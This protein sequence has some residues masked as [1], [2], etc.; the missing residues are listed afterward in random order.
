MLTSPINIAKYINNRSIKINWN[1][2]NFFPNLINFSDYKKEVGKR[3][4][5]NIYFSYKI[6]ID[7][8]PRHSTECLKYENVSKSE[9]ITLKKNVTYFT[10]SINEFLEFVTLWSSKILTFNTINSSLRSVDLCSE[11]KKQFH[12]TATTILERQNYKH[13]MFCTFL[14]MF[15][16]NL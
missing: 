1:S 5:F 7:L 12:K 6:F 15:S 10:S 2:K 11:F 14:K 3:S 4:S 8:C 13:G 16:H 9:V